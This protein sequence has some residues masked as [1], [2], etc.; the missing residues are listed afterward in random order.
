MAS[1][2]DSQVKEADWLL[3]GHQTA[4]KMPLNCCAH[5]VEQFVLR[6]F[7]VNAN[8]SKID[9]SCQYWEYYW[10]IKHHLLI[11]QLK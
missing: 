7:E 8:F 1:K 3:I 2:N 5:L 9:F 4:V 10:L 6:A 11:Q